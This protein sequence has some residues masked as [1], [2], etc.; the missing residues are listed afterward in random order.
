MQALTDVDLDVYPGEVVAIVGDNGA[1][2]STLVK[3]LAGV[4]GADS[5]DDHVRGQAASRSRAR[6]PPATSASPPCSRTSRCATTST[7]CRTSSSATRSGG[8][9]LDEVEMEKHSW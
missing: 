9:T 2:K 8:F 7:W 5:G 3:I 1:G 6:R 4:H